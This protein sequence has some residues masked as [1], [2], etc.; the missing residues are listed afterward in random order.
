MLGKISI[1]LRLTIL[2]VFLLTVC[3]VILTIILNFSA[4]RMANVI[5]ATV[6]TPAIQFDQIGELPLQNHRRLIPP[7]TTPTQY[8]LHRP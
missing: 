6:V 8:L 1:R 3:C 4:N 7:L 5:E 2:N